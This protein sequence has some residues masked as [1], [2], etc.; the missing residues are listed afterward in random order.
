M[1]EA[2]ANTLTAPRQ[3]LPPEAAGAF[4]RLD[5]RISTR[6]VLSWSEHCTEC[7]WPTCYTTCDLYSARP[8]GRCRRFVDGMVRVDCPDSANGYLL[9]IRFKQWGKLWT[10]GNLNLRSLSHARRIERR[11][12]RFGAV[13]HT[14]PIP[15]TFR[16][17]IVGKR[18]GLKKRLASRI[19]PPT[20]ER[21]TCFLL[22]CY[23]PADRSIP[24]SL[25]F[26]SAGKNNKIPF[27]RL[28]PL[29]PGFQL[30]RISFDEIAAVVDLNAPFNVEL[31]PNDF[32]NE[33][34][35]YFGLMEFVQ[36][37]EQKQATG[38]VKCVVW[39]L[40]NTL[41][42]GTLVEDGGSALHLK[43]GILDVMLNL[44]RHG[45]LQS[46]ASKNNHDEAVVI[47]KRL[48]IDHLFLYPQISWSPKGDGIR[49]IAQNLNIDIS[50]VLFV[51]D[52]EFE[53]AEVKSS[54]PHIQLMDAA[55]FTSLLHIPE[56]Q[57]PVTRE[58]A[59][60]R[61]MYVIEQERTALA[62]SFKDDYKA[63]LKHCEI[64]L[65][66]TS[67]VDENLE[68][69]HELTQRT[70]QMNFSGTRY[71]RERLREIIDTPYLHS[72]VLTCDDR[73]GSYGIV[74][75][76]LVDTRRPVLTDLM[77]SCRI[78]SKRIEHAFLAHIMGQYLEPGGPDFHALY[79]RTSRNAPSGQVFADLGMEELGVDNGLTSLL[80]P[81]GRKLPDDGI[82]E[83][84]TNPC[85]S[86]PL[87]QTA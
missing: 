37:V 12:H 6:T 45:V 63:F 11:D 68:R 20:R 64:R 21:P 55:E 62:T 31:I 15:S 26:R 32:E 49:A 72:Y 54:C 48:Q 18:Y 7:V 35:L 41:W 75:F 3:L 47:L 56:C 79:R 69:V 53:R 10:P 65:T 23:N 25:T 67:L 9:Q 59:S 78:Q 43:P 36:E 33:V 38:G 84:I 66:I 42:E 50:S 5:G 34:M 57:V 81:S 85:S 27:Q 14:I 83:I 86:T 61:E 8:D 58:S 70:N 16:N 44:D 4:A 22:E 60:R 30:V 17:V 77:F 24:L 13:L 19:V 74:G 28:A 39:D 82:V 40:D 29:E 87:G 51:D 1:Y 71:D 52:S 46:L 76:G 73:F 80:F 2:E